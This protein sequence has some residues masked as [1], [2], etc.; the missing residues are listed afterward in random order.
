[1]WK[2]FLTNEPYENMLQE[3]F[4]PWIRVHGPCS[5]RTQ[6]PV[7]AQHPRPLPSYDLPLRAHG[8]AVTMAVNERAVDSSTNN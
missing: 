4:L 8:F 5:W 3:G 6:L 7:L 2:S 1:M